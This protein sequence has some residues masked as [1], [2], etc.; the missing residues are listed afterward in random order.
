MPVGRENIA[1]AVVL[2]FHTSFEDNG[3]RDG[4]QHTLFPEPKQT[5]N[6]ISFSCRA[7]DVDRLL[8]MI[9]I[10]VIIIRRKED[11]RV[12]VVIYWRLTMERVQT[13]W[14]KQQIQLGTYNAIISTP[15][16]Y[17][18]SNHGWF[19]DGRV[20]TRK[21]RWFDSDENR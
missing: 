1:T 4:V 7:I 18:T 16:D 11:C 10:R 17:V 15:S 21:H 5:F 8:R 19:V 3:K 14:T 13:Q 9:H 20:F 2:Y 12:T 6:D